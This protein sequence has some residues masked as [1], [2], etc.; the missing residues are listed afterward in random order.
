MYLFSLEYANRGRDFTESQLT[1]SPAAMLVPLVRSVASEDK[2]SIEELHSS[3]EIDGSKALTHPSCANFSARLS[4]RSNSIIADTCLFRD[5][6]TCSDAHAEYSSLYAAHSLVR[7]IS[8]VMEL[9][10]RVR[11]RFVSL[12]E[13]IGI[14]YAPRMYD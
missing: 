8:E 7:E 11:M 14:V 5:C 2:R 3:V 1:G 4:A 13:A 6:P 12:I 10:R 9:R